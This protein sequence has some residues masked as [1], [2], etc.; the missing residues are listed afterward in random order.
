MDL[1]AYITKGIEQA[2]SLT[3]LA[4]EIGLI[5]ESLQAANAGKRGLPPVACGKL[6]DLVGAN[7]WDV[8]AASEII[9][10]KDEKKRAYLLPFVL[11]TSAL[12]TETLANAQTNKEG[13]R[14]GWDSQA[15]LTTTLN[16]MYFLVAERGAL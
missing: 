15:N 9:T 10:E 16:N 11:G 1:K 12:A 8:V 3:A 14:R 7:R 6:A 5:R 4:R 13:W 2:G